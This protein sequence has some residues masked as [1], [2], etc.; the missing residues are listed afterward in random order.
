MGGCE[1]D[2]SGY[3]MEETYDMLVFQCR[4]A[5]RRNTEE[6]KSSTP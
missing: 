6:I 2:V 5:A 1:D 4:T 3:A